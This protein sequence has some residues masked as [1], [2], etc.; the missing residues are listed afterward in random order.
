MTGRIVSIDTG[1]AYC[2]GVRAGRGSTPT[3]V[4]F[5]N[6]WA[7][8]QADALSRW[9]GFNTREQ[10]VISLNDGEA[11]AL[12][13]SAFE[14]GRS[15]HQ[16]AGYLRYDNP[17]YPWLVAGLLAKLYPSAGGEIALT[18]SLPVDGFA[19]AEKQI[20]RLAGRW[21]VEYHNGREVS[22]LNFIVYPENVVPEAFGSLCYFILAIDGSKFIDLEMAEGNVAIIDIGGYTTDILTFNALELGSVYGSVER[23]VINVRDDVNAAIKRQFQRSDLKTP[24]L[25]Q[26]IETRQYK[27]A[28][29]TLDVAEIVDKALWD[30]TDGVLDIWQNK[31]EAGVDYDAVV[32]TGGGAPLIAPILLKNIRHGNIKVMPKD[33]SHLANAIGAYRYALHLRSQGGN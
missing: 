5:P 30:L 12:G 32:F 20:E 3:T 1:N 10:L 29:D 19:R 6:A 4:A 25:D 2:K 22:N 9:Q 18:F 24:A 21:Q 17:E 11:L 27:H 16:R 26:V 31:L 15:Q 28:G 23:G 8:P 14:L 33:E 7:R 13:E